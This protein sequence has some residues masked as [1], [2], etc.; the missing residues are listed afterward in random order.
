MVSI[1]HWCLL[2]AVLWIDPYKITTRKLSYHLTGLLFL[3]LA[4][5]HLRTWALIFICQ[6]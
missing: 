4:N 1:E 3:W 2:V 5:Y 6:Y